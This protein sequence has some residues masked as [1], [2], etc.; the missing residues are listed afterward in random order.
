ELPL[1]IRQG[2]ALDLSAY[3][4]ETYDLTLLLGP[5][6]HLFTTQ[7]QHRA[8]SEALRVTKKGGVLMTAYCIA[9]AS[10]LMHGFVKGNVHQLIT[11]GLLDP[12][13]FIAR[14]RPQDLFQ[15]WR[16]EEIER[17]TASYPVQRLHYV[18]ADLAAN[19]QRQ[20]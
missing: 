5:M 8:F 6:Y 19:Y 3:L 1:H 10:I 18:A 2:N 4:D 15:L 12:E 20:A 7:D 9:D 14:S 13:H 11:D 16:K 17:L